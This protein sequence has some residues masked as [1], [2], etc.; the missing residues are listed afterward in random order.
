MIEFTVTSCS[1]DIMD[2]NLTSHELCTFLF[3]ALGSRPECEGTVSQ[4]DVSCSDEDF[5]SKV[6]GKVKYCKEQTLKERPWDT[7]GEHTVPLNVGLQ[8]FIAYDKKSVL[9]FRQLLLN[10]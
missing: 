1:K 6:A 3:K 5:I 8:K 2:T 9:S 10:Y 4:G 7:L